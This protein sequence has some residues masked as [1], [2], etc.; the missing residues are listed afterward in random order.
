LS[1]GE[2]CFHLVLTG[3]WLT[4]LNTSKLLLAHHQ[5][6]ITFIYFFGKGLKCYASWRVRISKELQD[7]LRYSKK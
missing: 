1:I 5:M 4:L 7:N 6:R 3:L 2:P